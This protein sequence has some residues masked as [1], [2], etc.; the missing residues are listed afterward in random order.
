MLVKQPLQAMVAAPL[1]MTR[2]TVDRFSA[3]LL[4]GQM[5]A[6]APRGTA[7]DTIA[8]LCSMVFK[9]KARP[10]NINRIG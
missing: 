1:G 3:Y 5:A 2:R 4:E 10:G 7:T 9:R 8:A 6:P